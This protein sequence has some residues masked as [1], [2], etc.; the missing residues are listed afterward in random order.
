M[1]ALRRHARWLPVLTDQG[2]QATQVMRYEHK[3]ISGVHGPAAADRDYTIV[4]IDWF[5]L[6]GNL[7]GSRC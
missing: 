6:D 4:T 2:I 7:G 1:R 3:R 5:A